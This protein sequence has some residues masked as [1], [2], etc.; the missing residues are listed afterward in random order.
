MQKIAF[1]GL[2]FGKKE[3]RMVISLTDLYGHVHQQMQTKVPPDT[4]YGFS[5]KTQIGGSRDFLFDTPHNHWKNPG[6]VGDGHS[7]RFTDAITAHIAKAEHLVDIVTMGNMTGPWWNQFGGAVI[8]GILLTALHQKP[9][10]V[11]ILMGNVLGK[12]GFAG[13]PDT[14]KLL[15]EIK[16]T[17]RGIEP[18]LYKL[19]IYA[20]SHCWRQNSWNHAKFIAVDGKS[21]ITGGHNLWTEAYLNQ[22]PIFDLSLRYDGSIAKGG[23]DFANGLWKFVCNHPRTSGNFVHSLNK[24]REIG[25]NCPSAQTPPAHHPTEGIPAMWVTN[26]GWGVF[27]KNGKDILE[28]T[29]MMALQKALPTATHCRLSQQ[30]LSSRMD[31]FAE[32]VATTQLLPVMAT[33]TKLSPASSP[34]GH[35]L[36]GFT[37]TYL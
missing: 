1:V 21:I 32:R 36:R 12:P 35:S 30:S 2:Y 14:T 23:H 17:A 22:K 25:E 11:R 9:I 19:D 8:R 7:I 24:Q 37:T 26:P 31:T 29:M 10:T 5:D 20:A 27:Q 4:L 18:H 6:T 3:N 15:G 13:A 34:E 16:E 33:P 28:S